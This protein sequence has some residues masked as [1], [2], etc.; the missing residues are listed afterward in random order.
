[1]LYK[2]SK[3]LDAKWSEVLDGRFF[4]IEIEDSF[5]LEREARPLAV[6]RHQFLEGGVLL[7][8]ELDD[9]AVLTHHLKTV[10]ISRVTASEITLRLMCSGLVAPSSP[11][12]LLSVSAEA[13][14]T[15]NSLQSEIHITGVSR[16]HR[17]S[18]TI[19]PQL[20]TGKCIGFHNS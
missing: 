15:G 3:R 8:F 17:G 16:V 1:M 7:D 14:L 13:I 4:Q 10:S 6:G 19:K 5:H 18:A 2:T 9:V 11:A 12:G 20:K